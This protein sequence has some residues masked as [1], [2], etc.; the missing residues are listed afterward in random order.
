MENIPKYNMKILFIA[1]TLG[2]G[3][4]ERQL[5]YLCYVL[6][7][8]NFEIKV[9]SLTQNEYFEHEIK[10]LGIDVI[11][12]GNSHN[13]FKRLFDI[14]QQ[15]KNFN[16][17]LIYG[18]HFYTGFYAG[19][20]GRITKILSFGSIRNDGFV[21]KKSNG[22]F[23]W[24]HFLLPNKIIANSNHGLENAI[25]AFYKKEIKLLP[26]IIDLELF[27]YIPRDKSNV[28]NLLFIGSLKQSKQPDLFIKLVEKLVGNG[29]DVKAIIIG[30]GILKEELMLLSKNLPVKFAG[31]IDD[32]KP[33]LYQS[34][35]LISTSLHEGTPNVVLEAM[36]TGTNIFALYH[37][38]LSKWVDEGL[39]L[40]TNNVD[41][42]AKHITN[43]VYNSH[44]KCRVFVE[45]NHS[46]KYVYIEILNLLKK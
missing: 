45:K 35:F 6:L 8:N 37:E 16:P 22:I 7:K 27:K 23:S 5:Y 29:I 36:A 25:K 9:L 2:R 43:H 18:F 38:G 3:G 11:F 1:G 19:L 12:V 14:Y 10:K 32:V 17:K 4:A 26:N 39:I 42:I 34:D 31:N 24:L 44:E 46:S 28:V 20:I 15:V 21:E 41:E 13:K 30:E 40:K 33:Y